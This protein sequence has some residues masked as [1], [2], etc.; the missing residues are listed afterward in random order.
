MKHVLRND[1]N[2]G[3]SVSMPEDVAQYLEQMFA[4]ERTRLE[5]VLRER[6]QEEAVR[7][8]GLPPQI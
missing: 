7:A 6:F 4:G 8:I 5:R 2:Q 3:P 1:R